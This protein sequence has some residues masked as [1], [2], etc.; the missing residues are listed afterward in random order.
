[1]GK[2]AETY[3]TQQSLACLG[4]WQWISQ[5][6]AC[7]LRMVERETLLAKCG[8]SMMH[9]YR[10]DVSDITT[11]RQTPE[12]LRLEFPVQTSGPTKKCN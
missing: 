12:I 6:V 4:S 10:D 1:M 3:G 9:V 8:G 11:P 7:E 2:S 5:N